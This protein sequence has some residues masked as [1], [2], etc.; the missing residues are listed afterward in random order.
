MSKK[1]IVGMLTQNSKAFD[2]YRNLVGDDFHIEKAVLK[3]KFTQGAYWTSLEKDLANQYFRD[4][5][6]IFG[7]KVKD[8]LKFIDH[9][10]EPIEKSGLGFTKK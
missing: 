9:G 1:M 4:E 2:D 7:I 5:V 6:W 3:K 10:F 8:A